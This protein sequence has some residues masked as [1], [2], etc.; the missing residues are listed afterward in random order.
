MLHS[1]IKAIMCEALPQVA[2][3][4]VEPSVLSIGFLPL[5]LISALISLMKVLVYIHFKLV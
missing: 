1:P 5:A 2:P 4:W 3:P